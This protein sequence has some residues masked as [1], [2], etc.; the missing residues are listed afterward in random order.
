[1]AE[2]DL[3]GLRAQFPALHQEVHGKS[4]VYLDNAA[5][6]HKPQCVIDALVRFYSRDNANV[7]RGVH[8]LSQRATDAFEAARRSL[9]RFVAA[10]SDDEIVFTR[11]TTEALNLVAHA[12]GRHNLRPGDEIV[13]SG[14][15]HHSNI[16][17]WQLVAAATGAVVRV[18]RLDRDG[19]IAAGEP[20]RVIGPRTRILSIVH[21]SNALGTVNPVAELVARARSFGALTV[22]DAAQLVPH[23]PFDVHAL[24]ADFVAFSGHKMFA[25]TGIGVLWGRAEVLAA[26]PPWQGGGDMIRSVSF[27]GS[28]WADAPSRFEAGTPSIADAVGLGAAADWMLGLDWEILRAHEADLLHYATDAVATVPGLRIIGTAKEKR[29]ILSFEVRGCHPHDLG[30]LLDCEGVAVRVGHHCAEPVM[31]HFGVP[32]TTR[33]SFAIYSTRSEVDRLVVALDKARRLLA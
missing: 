33:A 20:E 30:T 19:A 23:G 24:G 28:T 5:T 12:W 27:E 16:V 8:T 4:L 25:P 14:M 22:V 9:A 18:L 1:M 26:M 7:H 32:A 10:K 15:E 31:R 3:D 17:P 29:A 11:G 2:L 6:T 13:L 21:T